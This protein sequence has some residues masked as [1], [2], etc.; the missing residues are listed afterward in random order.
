MPR[1][2]RGLNPPARSQ[3]TELFNDL[4]AELKR[5]DGFGQPRIEEEHFPRTRLIKV[6]VIWDKWD[7]IPDEDRVEVILEAYEK[8]EGPE[9]RNRITLAIGLTVPEAHE[10]GLLPYEICTA[11]RKGDRVTLD[12]CKKAM[13]AVGGSTLF[14][15]GVVRLRLATQ[16][17][18]EASRRHLCEILPGSDEVWL[19]NK[20]LGPSER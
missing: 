2:T 11:V 3:H 8:V 18:A 4:A 13:L 10:I 7:R 17:E 20:D 6:T 12:D 1:I 5:K 9:F 19:I 15:P 16:A 14:E